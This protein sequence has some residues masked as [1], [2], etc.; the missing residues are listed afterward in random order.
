MR[1][2]TSIVLMLI[3][4][5]VAAA[6]GGGNEE[7]SGPNPPPAISGQQREV[8]ATIDGLES[9][10]RRGDGARI[11][12]QYLTKRMAEKLGGRGG[13]R[14]PKAATSLFPSDSQLAVGNIR[15][16]GQTV[17]VPTVDDRGRRSSLSMVKEG[18]RWRVDNVSA[19]PR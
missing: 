2:S 12:K 17:L 8:L 3:L 19:Q 11:C 6:C 7:R 16:S 10:S 15:T 1:G 9:G 14:C 4:G 18:G 13:K 5:A